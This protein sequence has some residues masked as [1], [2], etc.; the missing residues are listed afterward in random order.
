MDTLTHALSGALAVRAL[1][2]VGAAQSRVWAGFT[3][4]AFPDIDFALFWLAP[5]DFLNWHRGLTHSLLLAPLWA[6]L[7]ALAWSRL[8]P[9][10]GGWRPYYGVC[11]LGL[12]VH[13]LGDLI[14]L[15]G[16]QL[17]A[18]LSSTPYALEWTF[19]VD[20][21]L[22]LIVAVGFLA[23]QRSRPRRA[24][25][26]TLI[27]ATGYLA[28]Q[29]EMR[30]RVE[31][32]GALRA[33]AIGEPA[34]PVHAIPQ[35]F[36]PGTWKLVVAT[37]ASYAES[38]VAPLGAIAMDPAAS[39]WPLRVLAAYRPPGRLSS[40]QWPRIESV[41]D[42]DVAS[43]WEAPPM[44]PFR[45]FAALPTLYRID[46]SGES[47]CIWFTDLR[48]ALPAQPPAFRYGVCRVSR[49]TGWRPYRLRYFSENV[50][51]ALD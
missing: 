40:R 28:V 3:A 15:Y 13:L 46:R 10:P 25:V 19:D 27:A 38:Y 1:L 43:A 48:H 51:Q 39:W 42:P 45:R 33:A 5:Q 37:E 17:L 34:A 18:P 35:P 26:L 49:E 14:T 8:A 2:G 7:L 23:S 41:A 6:L 16:T 22:G 24:A 44:A 12:L 30:T 31:A 29:T 20:P 11:L 50:R 47:K 21:W 36:G 4:A 9:G 32:W